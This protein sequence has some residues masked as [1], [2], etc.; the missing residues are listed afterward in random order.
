LSNTLRSATSGIPTSQL[1]TWSNQGSV[2]NA[3]D[4]RE[5]IY[6][7]LQSGGFP[8]TECDIFLQ[9]SYG[10]STNTH[11]NSDVDI[12]T[13]YKGSYFYDDSALPDYQ[14]TWFHDETSRA[15]L[16]FSDYHALTV[17]VLKR[18]FGESMVKPG[19]KA[20]KVL[21]ENNR[22]PA[23]VLPC[24]PY[25]KFL[26]WRSPDDNEFVEGIRFVTQGESPPSVITNFP[27]Q[28][29]ENG[30]RKNAPDTTNQLYKPTVRMFKNAR[31][32]LTERNLLGNKVA[33]SY[34]VECLLYNVN[35]GSF[36]ADLKLRFELILFSLESARIENFLCQNGI[37]PLFGTGPDQWT[38]ADA[39][40]TINGWRFLWD[41]W[42]R[43]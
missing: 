29:L 14:R 12:V 9:G 5:T 21:G 42:G 8:W 6:G 4:T 34:F 22:L 1:S 27:K 26:R 30:R 2:S 11:G 7:A 19:T 43:V 13:L 37:T 20:I 31:R 32:Y 25:K 10:N 28:H 36:V 40:T 18:R 23:D 33:P 3:S 38:V 35:N 17:Q 24:F 41:N 16:T 39:K 15:S